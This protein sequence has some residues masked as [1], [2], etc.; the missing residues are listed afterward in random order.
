MTAMHNSWGGWARTGLAAAGLSALLVIA[1]CDNKSDTYQAPPPPK[2]TV[3]APVVRDVVEYADFTGNTAAVKSVE[4]RARVSGFLDSINF[5]PG[6]MVK[7]DQL[8]FVIEPEPFRAKLNQAKADLATAK[9]Q[10]ELAKA[11][12]LRKENA[13]KTRAVSEVEV[14]TAR[15]ELAKAKAGIQSAAA[16]VENAQID[17]GYTSIT[18]PIS[19][20]I[21]RNLVDVGNLVGSGQATLLATIYTDD[22][23]YAYFNISENDILSYQKALKSGQ[24][25]QAGLEPYAVYMGTADEVGYPRK[26]KLDYA[27]PNV[28]QSTGTVQVRGVFDNA[29]QSLLPGLFVR[30]R[31]PM[32]RLKD[33]V[34]VPEL[35]V[36]IDQG[37]NYL[38]VI[39]DQDVAQFRRV[40]MGP[41]EDTLAVVRTGLKAGERVVVNGLLRV[42]PGLKVTPETASA[43]AAPAKAASAS[44]PEKPAATA[45]APDKAANEASKN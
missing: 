23:M 25:A 10:E 26:G 16:E 15:A 22:P 21:S 44:A 34:L 27:D 18:A 1:A 31:I 7:K 30:I 39:D 33:A 3:A 14:L 5:E 40:T 6:G 17:L 29:D 19:G 8:L 20:R 32:Q 35:A 2:V 37:G 4:L 43:A 9:A 41:K 12:L 36:G 11:T 38:F 13:Y 42:R 45:P 28:D 24:L